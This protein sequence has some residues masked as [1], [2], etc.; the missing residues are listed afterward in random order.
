MGN[1][2]LLADYHPNGM[3][4]QNYNVAFVFSLNNKSGVA[5][6]MIQDDAEPVWH[7]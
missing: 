7:H 5:I 6:D 1:H 4:M 2:R 3:I